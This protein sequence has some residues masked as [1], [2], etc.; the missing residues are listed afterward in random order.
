[1]AFFIIWQSAWVGRTAARHASAWILFVLVELNKIFTTKN[2]LPNYRR[3]IISLYVISKQYLSVKLQMPV[4][5]FILTISLS[6]EGRSIWIVKKLRRKQTPKGDLCHG[7]V[8]SA[9]APVPGCAIDGF[10]HST[11]DADS[12]FFW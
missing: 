1:L 2:I 12:L 3:H 8:E 7:D 4:A 6:S 5:F 11:V 10:N 9:V